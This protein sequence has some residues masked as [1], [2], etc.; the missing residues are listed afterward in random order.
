MAKRLVEKGGWLPAPI[1]RDVIPDGIVL[2]DHSTLEWKK[3][4]EAPLDNRHK[5]RLLPKLRVLWQQRPALRL[6]IGVIGKALS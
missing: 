1:A 3:A 6:E 4:A 2:A 5:D